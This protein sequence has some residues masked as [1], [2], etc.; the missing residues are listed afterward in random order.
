MQRDPY[1]VLELTSAASDEQIDFKYR[2]LKQQYAEDRFLDGEAGNEAAKKLTELEQAYQEIKSS[3]GAKNSAENTGNM[4]KEVEEALR[5][6]DL[7]KAQEKLD[8]FSE[9]NAEWHYLQSVVFYKKN[10][11]NE[12]KKQ[13]EIAVRMDGANQ[14][15]RD[16][17]KNLEDKIKFNQQQAFTSGNANPQQEPERQM[18]GDPMASCCSALLCA[19]CLSTCCCR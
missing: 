4:F 2:A 15:Y 9:R 3:R 16:T 18:G 6:N 7:T 5:A 17:L 12:S 14:K 8:A 11:I 1:S 10:W 19:N 13:L